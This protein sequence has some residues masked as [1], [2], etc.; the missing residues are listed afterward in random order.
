MLS[1]SGIIPWLALVYST[2]QLSYRH[3]TDVS[4]WNSWWQ[5]N[6]RFWSSINTLS[7]STF[8]WDLSASPLISYLQSSSICAQDYHPKIEM[9]NWLNVSLSVDNLIL[10]HTLCTWVSLKW[11]TIC[12]TDW[13]DGSLWQCSKCKRWAFQVFRCVSTVDSRLKTFVKSNSYQL[14]SARYNSISFM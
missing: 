4:Q 6:S 14:C 13:K 9:Q 2:L 7:M 12:D 11:Y 8:W 1:D 5:N 3:L 10:L